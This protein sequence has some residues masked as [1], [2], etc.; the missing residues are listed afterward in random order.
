MKG[1]G[2]EINDAQIEVLADYL[3]QYFGPEP[4]AEP[5]GGLIARPLGVET[6][7]LGGDLA[8]GARNDAAAR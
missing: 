5:E 2:A 1:H 7:A 8:A 4:S 3:A 6:R